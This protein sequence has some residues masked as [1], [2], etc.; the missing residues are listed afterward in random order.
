MFRAE[1]NEIF[2]NSS[3][4][5]NE[6]V[7]NLS[8]K[9]MSMLNIRAMRKSNFLIPNAK[10]TL[11]YLRLAFIKALILQHF[12]LES[13]IRIETNLSGYAIDRVLS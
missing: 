8:R 7:M 2:G 4:R 5:A 10:K 6:I 12:D 9:L 3:G 13:H 11:N 1:N